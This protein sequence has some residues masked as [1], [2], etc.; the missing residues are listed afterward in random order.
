M[1]KASNFTLNKKQLHEGLVSLYLRLNGYFTAGFIVHSP[2]RNKNLTEIDFLAVRFPHSIEPERKVETA[3]ELEA[4][5]DRIDFLVC[6]VK[7]GK[8]KSPRFNRRLLRDPFALASAFRRAGLF[9]TQDVPKIVEKL[10]QKIQPDKL[11][12]ADIPKVHYK[13]AKSAHCFLQQ[14]EEP[15]GLSKHLPY[16]ASKFLVIYGNAL[17]PI[18]L[19]QLVRQRTIMNCGVSRH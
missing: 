16:M 11:A 12:G 13:I 6:E 3:K 2:I 18:N 7:G 19:V 14:G 17:D 1:V 5:N 4:P 15:E 8:K 9:P 10:I